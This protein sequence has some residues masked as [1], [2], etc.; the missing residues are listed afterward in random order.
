V[1]SGQDKVGKWVKE[2]IHLFDDFRRAFPGEEPGEVEAL[3]FLADTDN[4]QS[5]V[6]AGF[7]DLT[8]LCEKSVG[9]HVSE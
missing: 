5:Q 1:E 2:R 6:T 4:T 9:G 7:D 8:I 3:A